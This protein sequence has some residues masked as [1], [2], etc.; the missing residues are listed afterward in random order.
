MNITETA[1]NIGHK[2]KTCLG[3]LRR[4]YS[5]E[6]LRRELRISHGDI[7]PDD[8]LRF[9][10]DETERLFIMLSG[11]GLHH[12]L[13]R[14]PLVLPGYFPGINLFLKQKQQLNELPDADI[15]QLLTQQARAK[16]E[17]W[18]YHQR[19]PRIVS[20]VHHLPN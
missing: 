14:D 13:L 19:A 1:R 12:L 2:A 10:S 16:L 18:H 17:S 3:D 4:G 6:D 11:V 5:D 7:L 9:K 20:P 15:D 8:R